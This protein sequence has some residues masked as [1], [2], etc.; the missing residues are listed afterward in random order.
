MYKNAFAPGVD[1]S[2]YTNNQ[3]DWNL[4]MNCLPMEI[5][6]NSTILDLSNKYRLDFFDLLTYLKEWKNKKL[7][8]F[9]KI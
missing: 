7:I 9:V 2:K 5:E 4:L 1:N 3:R 6:K 8:K